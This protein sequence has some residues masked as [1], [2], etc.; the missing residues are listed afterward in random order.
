MFPALGFGGRL[1]PN[2]EV[3][4]EFFLNGSPDNPYCQG[5]EGILQAYQGSLQRG[6]LGN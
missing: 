2:W 1:P 3:S 5:V 4:H 6:R